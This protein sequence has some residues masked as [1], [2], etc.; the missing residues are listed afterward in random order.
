MKRKQKGE[1]V[2][3]V[4]VAYLVAGFLV[5]ATNGGSRSL[6]AQ[7]PAQT[8]QVCHNYNGGFCK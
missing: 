2:I 5:L 6:V 1:V 7:A 3:A 8:A 4:T